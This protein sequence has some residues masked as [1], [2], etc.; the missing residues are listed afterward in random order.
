[1]VTVLALLLVPATAAGYGYWYCWWNDEPL[2]WHDLPVEYT[3]NPYMASPYPG[4]P[5]GDDFA[6]AA[7]KWDIVRGQG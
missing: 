1:M 7:Y 4:E 5:G 3:L 2:T 6:N